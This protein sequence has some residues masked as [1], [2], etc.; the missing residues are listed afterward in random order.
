MDWRLVVG[1]KLHVVEGRGSYHSHQPRLETAVLEYLAGSSMLLV[2][3]HSCAAGTQLV[4][5]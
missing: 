5:T 4:V 2:A 3:A 1:A